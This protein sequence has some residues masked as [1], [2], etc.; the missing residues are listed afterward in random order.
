MRTIETDVG[1]SLREAA[2]DVAEAWKA[3]EAGRPGAGGDRILFRDWAALCAVLTPKRYEL[4]R[5]LR[6]SPEAGIRPLARA[7]GRDVRRVHEDVIALAELGLV[8]RGEDGGLS[9][10]VDEITST[11]RIAA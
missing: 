2:A 3:A 11:I 5:H 7:L 9:S 1:R 4:L 6:R 8:L 10:E